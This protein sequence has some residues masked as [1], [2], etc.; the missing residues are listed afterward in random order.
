LLRL[1]LLVGGKEI[2]RN[3]ADDSAVQHIKTSAEAI[4][5]LTKIYG[6][7]EDAGVNANISFDLGLINHTDYYTGVIF[8]VYAAGTGFPVAG[9]GR[10]D[11]L[12][13]K[14]G[15][16]TPAVGATVKLNSVIDIYL[17]GGGNADYLQKDVR[18]ILVAYTAD[19]RKTAFNFA[20]KLRAEGITAEIS[21]LTEDVFKNIEYAKH[22]FINELIIFNKDNKVVQVDVLTGTKHKTGVSKLFEAF[23]IKEGK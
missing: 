19:A 2:L 1:P 10:Y 18:K 13:E 9:G 6:F 14:F 11:N 4:E 8:R 15:K 22:K 20:E 12:C 3:Y 16:K 21:F 5:R 7:L 23:N 17:N